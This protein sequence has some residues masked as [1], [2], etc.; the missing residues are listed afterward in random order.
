MQ[1]PF[2]SPPPFRGLSDAAL[3]TIRDALT[4]GRLRPGERLLEEEVARQMGISRAPV[5]EAF[6]Q[7]EL[8]GLIVSRPHRGTFVATLTPADAREVYSL[9]AAL[10][11]HATFSI[12]HSASD[13]ELHE[14]LDLAKAMQPPAQAN[15]LSGLVERDFRFHKRLCELTGQTRL[16]RVWDS[17]STQIR[18]FITITQRMYLPPLEISRRHVALAE[19]LVRREAET[20]RALIVADITEVGEYV[21]A[22]LRAAGEDATSRAEARDG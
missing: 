10:E 1:E 15:D 18:A 14:L 3:V 5:R 19:A 7:L 16:M 20:A 12:C 13:A 9:R 6:R 21:A 11:G 8:E 2:A 17:M 4:N 22:G